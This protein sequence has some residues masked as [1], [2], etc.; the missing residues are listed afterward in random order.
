MTEFT[1]YFIPV[2]YKKNKPFLEGSF[3]ERFAF[4]NKFDD[5]TQIALIS[6]SETRNSYSGK[7]NTD[8]NLIRTYLYKLANIDKINITDIGEL[9][10]G[11]SV[12]DTYT[13][14]K[15]VTNYL[16]QK[17]IVP[18]F[19]GGSQDLTIPL[20]RGLS[21]L[22]EEI[23]LSVID[24]RIDAD[25]NEFH[26]QSYLNQINKEFNNVYV[27]IL[28][29]QSY[30]IP[31]HIIITAEKNNWDLYRLGLIRNNFKQIEPVLR[32]SDIVSF[33]LS[34]V[35]QSDNQGAVFQSPNG[36]YAEE[37]CQL[38]SLSGLSD[39]IKVFSFFEYNNSLDIQ[40][41]SAH[42]AA[43]IIWYFLYG[44]SQRKKDYPVKGLNNYKKIFVKIEKT[45]TELIFYKNILNSRFWVEIPV[46]KADKKII[47]CSENDYIKACNNE[48]SDRIWKN[49]SRNF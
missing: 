1:D 41:N 8:I 25:D 17:N 6:L 19:F 14:V 22:H 46:K 31:K 36:L 33:D 45:D 4:E 11:N 20:L 38:A 15:D 7:Y 32:D 34:S 9:K 5:K 24:A 21:N 13:S 29:Y 23:E 28:G 40:K 16:L 18:V 35:R 3:G 37:A 39:K 42:L 44:I 27:S 26:S 30:F 43:Q 47:S 49:I 2:N 10:T 48:I 12:K